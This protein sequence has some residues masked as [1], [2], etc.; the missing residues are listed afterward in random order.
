MVP[1]S[2]RS[3]PVRRRISVDLPLPFGPISPWTDPAA[4]SSDTPFSARVWPKDFATSL[5]STETDIRMFPTIFLLE[6][7]LRADASRLS[8]GKTGI[9]F[10]GSCSHLGAD[11]FHEIPTGIGKFELQAF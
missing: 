9:H 10:S 8:R 6:H 11:P 1:L 2:A 5:I 7:D 4:I 3:R